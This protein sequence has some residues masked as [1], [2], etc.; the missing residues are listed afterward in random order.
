MKS[1]RSNGAYDFTKFY[2]AEENYSIEVTISGLYMIS[3][4]VEI[5]TII[6]KLICLD[7]FLLSFMHKKIS[8]L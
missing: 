6:F 3:V 4:Q 1:S 7:I 2:L 8:H 5:Q